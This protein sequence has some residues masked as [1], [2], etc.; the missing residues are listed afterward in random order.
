MRPKILTV[1]DA[2]AVRRIVQQALAACD[3]DVSEATNGFNALFPMERALPDLMLLDLNMPVMGGLELLTKMRSHPVLRGLPVIMLTSPAD[4]AVLGELAALG[5]SGVVQ[6]P[7]DP[8]ALL[9]TIRGVINLRPV[10]PVK[11]AA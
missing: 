1:D 8:T 11:P 9:E 5:V 2:K 6:K 3:C 7:F 4:H 10:P